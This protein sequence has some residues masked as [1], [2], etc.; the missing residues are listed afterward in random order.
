M[1]AE[2]VEV[3]RRLFRAVEAR[4]IELMYDI[5]AR[6]V[7]VREAPSLPYGGATPGSSSTVEATSKRG[8]TY[9]P[10]KIGSWTPNSS[11]PATACSCAGASAPTAWTARAW[12]YR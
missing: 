12:T 4:D 2:N 11:T 3:I 9:R 5:Y 1:T 7:I 6:D 10:T 8:I